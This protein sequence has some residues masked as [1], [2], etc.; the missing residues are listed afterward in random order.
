MKVPDD[1]FRCEPVP[2]GWYFDRLDLSVKIKWRWLAVF[3]AKVWW[4]INGS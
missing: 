2:I 3:Y 4:R 1:L